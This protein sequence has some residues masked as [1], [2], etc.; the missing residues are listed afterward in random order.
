MEPRRFGGPWVRRAMMGISVLA[1]VGGLLI[2]GLLMGSH[3]PFRSDPAA[4]QNA[5]RRTGKWQAIYLFGANCPCSAKAST[6]LVGRPPLSGIDERIVFVGAEPDTER[7][8]EDGG[9]RLERRTPEQARDIYG[10]RSAPLL[11]FVDPEGRIRYT[12]GFAHRSDFA[13]GFHEPRIWEELRA[14]REVTA[15]PAYGCAL[16]FGCG[17][18]SLQEL[19]GN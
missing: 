8:L 18:G 7:P 9:W 14:G 1:T 6:H 13:D 10:A 12:G 3:M 15:L 16:R 11:I 4:A 5:A 19:R 17:A 2:T